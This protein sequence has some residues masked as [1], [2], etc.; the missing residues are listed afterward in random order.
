[1]KR[2]PRWVSPETSVEIAAAWMRD[3]QIG[4]LPVCS[5]TGQVLGTITDR[6]IA[7]RVVAAALPAAT[8][9]REAMTPRV[10]AV[11][12][13]DNMRNAE[14]LMGAEQVSRLV[15]IDDDGRLVGVIS[16][17]DIAAH[18]RAGRA[19]RVLREVARREVREQVGN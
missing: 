11:H 10:I 9:V 7:I 14:S 17:S 5:V 6:D 13:D 15:V 12:P 1:M 19:G 8:A 4:F 2:T 18:E 16:L 3:A